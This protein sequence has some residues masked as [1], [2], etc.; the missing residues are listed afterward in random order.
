MEVLRLYEG[1]EIIPLETIHDVS[2]SL[3][4]ESDFSE[5][6]ASLVSDADSPDETNNG[7]ETVY[8]DEDAFLKA[9]VETRL[10]PAAGT[11]LPVAAAYAAY[12]STAAEHDI[13]VRNTSWFSQKLSETSRSTGLESE[14]TGHRPG[15]TS[16]SISSTS[17]H[18]GRLCCQFDAERDGMDSISGLRNPN[19]S[20][21][22]ENRYTARRDGKYRVIEMPSRDTHR[23]R[24]TA[25]RDGNMSTMCFNVSRHGLASRRAVMRFSLVERGV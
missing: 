15:V 22:A 1:G 18:D 2:A 20:V 12:A 13:P 3:G 17:D 21:T 11:Y 16:V 5:H 25:P 4:R 8:D 10:V 7:D 6:P 24:R 23:N 9:F 19:R 14:S